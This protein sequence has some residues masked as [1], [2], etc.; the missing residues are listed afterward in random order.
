[1]EEYVKIMAHVEGE[2]EPRQFS[3]VRDAVDYAKTYHPRVTTIHGW[4]QHKGRL[5]IAATWVW[6]TLEYSSVTHYPY[7]GE[8]KKEF[9]W[10]ERQLACRYAGQNSSTKRVKRERRHI[11]CLIS[12]AV[13]VWDNTCGHRPSLHGIMVNALNDACWRLQR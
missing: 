3:A 10:L 4:K 1:M 2:A 5:F 6:P 7:S 11:R 13:F 8:Y 12:H 9:A